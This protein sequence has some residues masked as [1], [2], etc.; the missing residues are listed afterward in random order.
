MSDDAVLIVGNHIDDFFS[1]FLVVATSGTIFAANYTGCSTGCINVSDV[2]VLVVRNHIDD[3]FS[4]F[5]VVVT[6]STVRTANYTGCGAG[7]INVSDVAL[8]VV[9]E[10]SNYAIL[11]G[12]F[13]STLCIGVNLA[14]FRAS[15]V[16]PVARSGAGCVD[17]FCLCKCVRTTNFGNS[18]TGKNGISAILFFQNL[19][20]LNRMLHVVRSKDVI[21]GIGR[22]CSRD[23]F[24]SLGSI[25]ELG[26][27]SQILVSDAIGS[28]VSV[29]ATG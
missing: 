1:C 11:G 23:G 6:N 17:C 24:C 28:R 27:L 25:D 9:T 4:C 12:N 5:L 22:I 21:A 13:N 16:F 14:A 26:V 18:Y 20:A 19:V 2:A 29:K 10:S 8:V 3:C 15:V 7:C